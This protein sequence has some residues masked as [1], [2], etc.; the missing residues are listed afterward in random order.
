M[1]PSESGPSAQI[2]RRLEALPRKSSESIESQGDSKRPLDNRMNGATY[3]AV[4]GVGHGG[5]VAAARA[6]S[7]FLDRLLYPLMLAICA[8]ACSDGADLPMAMMAPDDTDFGEGSEPRSRTSAGVEDSMVASTSDDVAPPTAE[9]AAEV[10]V[11]PIWRL[12]ACAK[13][14]HGPNFVPEFGSFSSMGCG[15]TVASYQTILEQITVDC[16]GNPNFSCVPPPMSSKFDAAWANRSGP[17]AD[18]AMVQCD[19]SKP[20]FMKPDSPLW[21]LRTS[22]SPSTW[23]VMYFSLVLN[24]M[25]HKRSMPV[26][27][28]SAI[29]GYVDIVLAVPLICSGRGN[30]LQK[31]TY[32]YNPFHNLVTYFSPEQ[33]SHCLPWPSSPYSL[34]SHGRWLH[35]YRFLCGIVVDFRLRFVSTDSSVWFEHY[36][37]AIFTAQTE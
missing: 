2:A 12:P 25:A 36:G 21:D 16:G 34:A 6:S 17:E 35:I 14:Q 9:I 23:P 27:A 8:S 1:R 10:A 24:R 5:R 26:N 22:P 4:V 15:P 11:S 29:K 32:A 19:G 18:F 37:K 20:R 7:A 13:S 30:S 28:E 3:F 33:S 31:S